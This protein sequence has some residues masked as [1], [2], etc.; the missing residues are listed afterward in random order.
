MPDR[1][2]V[3]GTA[4]AGMNALGM[5]ATILGVPFLIAARLTR[6]RRAL[7]LPVALAIGAGLTVT[8]RRTGWAL[9]KLWLGIE[10]SAT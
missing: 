2:D 3:R 10:R 1:D 4:L 6:G 8:T 9:V 7:T 5:A